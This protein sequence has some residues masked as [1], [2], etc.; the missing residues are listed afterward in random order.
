MYD[1]K[2]YN[3]CLI[4]SFFVA[5]LKSSNH[6][7][8]G[9]L[10]QS[11][12][13]TPHRRVQHFFWLR[14]WALRIPRKSTINIDIHFQLPSNTFLSKEYAESLNRKKNSFWMLKNYLFFSF[15]CEFFCPATAF[16]KIYFDCGKYSWLR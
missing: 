13:I 4:Y 15:L 1:S 7:K 8:L 6:G 10:L 14:L 11:L 3:F 5:C 2:G 9:I 16:Q 12:A